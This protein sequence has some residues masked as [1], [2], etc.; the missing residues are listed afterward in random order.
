MVITHEIIKN[1]GVS[2]NMKEGFINFLFLVLGSGI[3]VTV[4][5]LVQAGK[6]AD[7]QMKE[8]RNEK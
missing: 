3:G 4:M 1:K 8:W 2:E 5:S 6:E 7:K